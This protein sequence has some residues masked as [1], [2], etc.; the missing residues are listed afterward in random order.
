MSVPRTVDVEGVLQGIRIDVE[1]KRVIVSA[2]TRV[3][4]S[5]GALATFNVDVTDLL[6]AADRN[7]VL[8]LVN[9]AQAWIDS[10]V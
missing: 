3:V 2:M 5:N 8:T 4:G 1:A 9:H 7:N 6:T 10:Q